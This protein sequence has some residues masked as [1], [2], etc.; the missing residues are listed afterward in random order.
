M[1][2]KLENLG[3]GNPREEDMKNRVIAFVPSLPIPDYLVGEIQSKLAYVD[4][5]IASAQVSSE[6][7]VLHITPASS[8]E[9][10]LET[11][12]YEAELEEKVQRVVLSMAEGAIR[13]KV[14]ILEDHLDRQVPFR[15]D[16]MPGLLSQGEVSQEASG[17]FTVGSLLTRLIS[18]F[19]DQFL[20]LAESFEAKPYRFPTL[21]PACAGLTII[22]FFNLLLI[23]QKTVIE[24]R[25]ARQL[26]TLLNSA[27][28]QKN[29]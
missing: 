21:I 24:D 28:S 25:K 20:N 29:I 22:M 15:N 16:P 14:Q 19:E 12:E 5:R 8:D 1:S 2:N 18:Y 23:I 9:P 27:N 10:I 11:T 7:I 4:E 26:T 3:I 13:P 17:I 6:R